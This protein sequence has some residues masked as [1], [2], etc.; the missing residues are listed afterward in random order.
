MNRFERDLWICDI[1]HSIVAQIGGSD[2]GGSSNQ[3]SQQSSSGTSSVAANQTGQYA[4]GP[5]NSQQIQGALDQGQNLATNGNAL[6][7]AGFGNVNSAANAGTSLYGTGN[8][9]LQGIL[10]GSQIQAGNP[11]FQALV[12][13][14]NQGLQPTVQGAF[15]GAGRFGSGGAD[16][17]YTNALANATAPLAYQNFT[18]Q[19]GNQLSALNNLGSYTAG[20]FNPGQAQV[21]AGYTPTNQF[22][23]QLASLN[24]GTAGSGSSVS[25]QNTQTTGNSQGIGQGSQ[26][27]F[28]VNAAAKK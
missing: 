2:S 13:Q 9:T 14:I 12:G 27:N 15:E 10:N 18:A 8:T 26:S 20:S 28:G 6:T 23:Q 19:Q 22:T 4:N 17:A 25:N 3:S 1:Y 16:N 21:T 7:N 5:I 11:N 24:P